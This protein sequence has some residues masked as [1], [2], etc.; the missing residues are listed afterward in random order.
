MCRNPRK[1]GYE[2]LTLQEMKDIE[3]VASEFEL[4]DDLRDA[5]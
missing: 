1:S 2:P 4:L 5:A 3:F